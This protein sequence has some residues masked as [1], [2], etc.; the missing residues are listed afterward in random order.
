MLFRS[1]IVAPL[2]TGHHP[3]PFRIRCRFAGK[4]GHVVLDQIRTVDRTRLTKRMGAVSEPTVRLALE[5]LQE[6]FSW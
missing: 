6:M 1:V 4:T 2:T 5:R 3:Y